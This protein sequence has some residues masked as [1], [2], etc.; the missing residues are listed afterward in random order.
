MPVD[1]QVV[2]RNVWNFQRRYTW[3]SY[4]CL[5]RKGELKKL[6]KKKKNDKSVQLQD[7]W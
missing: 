5:S 1:L 3:K 4:R 7:P 6:E 2:L